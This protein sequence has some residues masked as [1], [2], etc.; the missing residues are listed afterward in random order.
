MCSCSKGI[1]QTEIIFSTRSSAAAHEIGSTLDALKRSA[2]SQLFSTYVKI[3]FHIARNY[4]Y[5]NVEIRKREFNFEHC[6]GTMST[7]SQIINKSV[8]RPSKCHNRVSLFEYGGLSV[9]LGLT[10]RARVSE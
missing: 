8:E 3:Y 1:L 6:C 7:N 2:P 10:F 4:N 5:K 9:I